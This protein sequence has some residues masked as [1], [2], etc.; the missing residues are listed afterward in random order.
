MKTIFVLHL[1]VISFIAGLL[2]CQTGSPDLKDPN[3]TAAESQVEIGDSAS[4]QSYLKEEL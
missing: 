3:Q 1:I 4:I 2:L